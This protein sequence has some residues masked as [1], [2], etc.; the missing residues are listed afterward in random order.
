MSLVYRVYNVS[1]SGGPI[2]FLNSSCRGH[3][4]SLVY[5]V[6]DMGEGSGWT[7]PLFE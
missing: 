7:N 1:D 4:M 2:V 5:R 3:Q 6:D